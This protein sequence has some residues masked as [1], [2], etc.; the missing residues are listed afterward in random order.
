LAQ[1]D[2]ANPTCGYDFPNEAAARRFADAHGTESRAVVVCSPDELTID[3]D[4]E[5]AKA[6][7]LG[8]PVSVTGHRRNNRPRVAAVSDDVLA[9]VDD[10]VVDPADAAAYALIAKLDGAVDPLWEGCGRKADD[11]ENLREK[12]ITK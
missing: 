11:L 9:L 2:W 7:P 4:E 10:L 3:P 8:L 12:E 5:A 1:R 6:P